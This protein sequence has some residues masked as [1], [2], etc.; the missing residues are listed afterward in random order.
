MFFKHGDN[1]EKENQK[2]RKTPRLQIL[3]QTKQ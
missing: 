3:D 2:L 1:R